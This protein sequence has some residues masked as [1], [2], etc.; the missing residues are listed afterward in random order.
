MTDQPNTQSDEP[1]SMATFITGGTKVTEKTLAGV[2]RVTVDGVTKTEY[3][4]TT[5]AEYSIGG[6]EESQ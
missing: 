6:H 5:T 1:K 3:T 4:F 2:R